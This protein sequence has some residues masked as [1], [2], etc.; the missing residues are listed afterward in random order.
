MTE[1]KEILLITREK[2]FERARHLKRENEL[3]Y[4]VKFIIDHKYLPLDILIPTQR[5]LSE[6][7]LLIVLQ[8]IKHG[9]DAPII[10]LEHQKKYYIL[11]GHH[12]AYALKKL[13]FSQVECLIL[14]PKKEIKT[15]IEETVQRS[16][17]K[18]LDDIKIVRNKH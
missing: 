15:K 11:D 9:Y 13:G 12:R 6:A 18:S 10:V 2:A 1:K 3:I 7:K 5:E 4:G 8:E 14:K 16:K 17:L